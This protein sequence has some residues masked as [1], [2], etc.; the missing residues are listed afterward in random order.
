MMNW[1]E[2]QFD[3]LFATVDGLRVH[4]K[5]AGSGTSI[6]LLHNSGGSL[7]SVQRLADL[8]STTFDVVRL[9]LPGFG[10]T[11]PRSDR[12]YRIRTYAATVARFMA[13]IG[14]SRYTV[15]GHSLGG[16]IAWNLALDYP[17]HVAA[18]VLI[19]ATGYPEKTVPP[20]FRLMHNPLLR[21]LFRRWMPRS[22]TARSLRMAVGSHSEIV[23]EAMVERVHTLTGRPGN[24]SALVDLVNTDQIDRSEEITRIAAPTLI[25]RSA[26]INAQ[27]FARDIQNSQERVHA[28]GGHLLPEEEPDWVANAIQRFMH[29]LDNT[30]LSH[31]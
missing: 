8:L 11:G 1:L 12:D 10:L 5:R 24:R 27:R 22:A 7:H 9:D 2:P 17:D 30:C 15:V 23:D 6:V 20:A 29:D 21:P 13:R 31:K 19:N 28:D 14:V 18:L 25:L 26:M 4:Y 3:S 16:N